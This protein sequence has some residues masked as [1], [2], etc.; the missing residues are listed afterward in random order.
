MATYK[1]K[2]I[3]KNCLL[4]EYRTNNGSLK[5]ILVGVLEGWDKKRIE[6]AI[7]EAKQLKDTEDI[8]LKLD[9]YFSKGEEL[10][11]RY[12][13]SE[14]EKE[15]KMLEEFEEEQRLLTEQRNQELLDFFTS[16]R[17]TPVDYAGIRW[18]EYP[19]FEDQLD[20]LY[21]MRQGVME[22]IQEI[23]RRIKEVK[24]KYPK[25]VPTNLT[26]ADLD[27]MFPK[28]RP[29]DYLDDLRSRG[30]QADFL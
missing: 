24:E 10:E 4:I 25:D 19:T 8:D 17:N 26:N 28:S 11:F 15:Q 9:Q 21:W 3:L 13:P 7:T 30:I 23:D 22:P 18:Y 29:T 20:A 14:E 5:E 1:I 16:Y 2:S 6:E 12:V 27:E